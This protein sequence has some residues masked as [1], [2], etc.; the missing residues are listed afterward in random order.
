MFDALVIP[1]L[2]YYFRKHHNWAL[3]GTLAAA[4]LAVFFNRNFGGA[5]FVS[6]FVSLMIFSRLC[7]QKGNRRFLGASLVLSAILFVALL[8]FPASGS[9]TFFLDNLLGFFSFK[10]SQ[11][12]VLFTLFYFLISYFFL[13][14]IRRRN[15]PEKH[16]FVFTFTYMQLLFLYFFW[17]GLNNH[18]LH[19]IQFAGLQFFLMLKIAGNHYEDNNKVSLFI[20][21]LVSLCAAAAV[22]FV[23]ACMGDFYSNSRGFGKSDFKKNFLNKRIYRWD[24]ERARLITTINPRPVKESVSLI[25]KYSPK[26]NKGIYIISKYDNILPFLA[27]RYSKMPSFYLQ[28]YLRDNIST[29]HAVFLVLRDLP[30]YIY[31]DSDLEDEPKDPWS[32]LFNETFI[33]KERKSRFGRYKELRMVFKAVKQN[34]VYADSSGLLTVYKLVI[35][36]KAANRKSRAF[37]EKDTR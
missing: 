20:K 7:R 23:L 11:G 5:L 28:N 16:L 14:L 2:F 22:L 30:E 4:L 18:L 13:H 15:A 17:S 31:V 36:P 26:K 34:Y 33:K 25:H 8:V 9:H 24:F 37:D 32:F 21:R 10:P 27:E 29:K 35:S 6:V 12:S 19:V 3:A 1:L